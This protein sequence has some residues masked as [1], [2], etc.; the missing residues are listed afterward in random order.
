[1]TDSEI[2]NFRKMA[3]SLNDGTYGFIELEKAVNEILWDLGSYLDDYLIMSKKMTNKLEE[4]IDEMQK[5]DNE[6]K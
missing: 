5:Q 4:T 3:G 2:I 6:T 1:M